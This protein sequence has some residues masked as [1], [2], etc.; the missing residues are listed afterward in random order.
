M[1]TIEA[2]V[3]IAAPPS[4]VSEVLLDIDAAPLWTTGLERV[5]VIEGSVGEPGCVGHAHYVEGGRRYV[6]EDRLI[7]AEPGSHFT[8]ELRGGGLMA[9]VE[10]SL[11]EIPIGTRLTIRW[12]GTGTTVLTRLAL[13]FMG[14]RVTRRMREDLDALRRLVEHRHGGTEGANDGT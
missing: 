9:T 7:E 11:D 4:V 5:E 6:L 10:T 1:T 13:P 3:E 14:R 12:R 8:S 2:S